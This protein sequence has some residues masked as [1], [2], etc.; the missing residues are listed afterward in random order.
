MESAIGRPVGDMVVLVFQ[1]IREALPR[2]FGLWLAYRITRAVYNISPLH[3]LSHIS[4]PKLAAMS[5]LYEFWF[6][7]VKF[8]RYSMEIKRMHDVYG[9]L[10][11]ISPDEVHCNDPS[12]VDEIYASGGRRREK[13][14]HWASSLAGPVAVSI[15]TTIDHDVH[16]R[17]RQSMANS[18]SRSA[19]CKSEPVIHAKVQRLCDKLLRYPSRKVFDVTSA[20]SC[21]TTDVITDYCFGEP[22][23]LLEQDDWEPNF[24]APTNAMQDA[25]PLFKFFPAA[26]WFAD[27][28][29][30][31]AKLMGPEMAFFIKSITEDMPGRVIK[32]KEAVAS[33]LVR[34]RTAVFEDIL[35]SPTLPESDK[36][37]YRLTGDG[38][39]L[40]SAGTETSAARLEKLPYLTAVI[41]EGLRLSYGIAARL[42][43]VAPDEDLIYRDTRDGTGGRAYVIPRGYAVGMSTVIAHHDESIF[44][45][46]HRFLPERWLDAHD[47]RRPELEKHMLSFSRGSRVC[48]GM[49]LAWCN[50]YL[51]TAALMLR[52]FPRMELYETTLD[53]VQYDHD[54]FVSRPKVGTKGVRVVMP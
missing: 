28:F 15:L 44:P 14:A 4:G 20:Y 39:I 34:E 47:E 41:L 37:V 38:M 23:G 29:P 6:D 12:M 33:N 26:H 48:V 22:F 8:G 42:P 3:P 21:F 27:V 43:R 51:A 45:D 50:L 1:V 36:S 32:A 2:L 53:D 17:R 30:K 16:R 40:V 25:Q 18:F 13:S 52:V 7:V 10:V 46:S 9:P 35:R 11:R 24:R 5:I 54:A 31:L 49:Q 19:I